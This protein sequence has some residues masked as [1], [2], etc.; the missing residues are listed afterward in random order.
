MKVENLVLINQSHQIGHDYPIRQSNPSKYFCSLSNYDHLAWIN[1][2]N[3]GN[4]IDP[5]I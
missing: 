2:K 4:N 1:Q 3:T 5:T